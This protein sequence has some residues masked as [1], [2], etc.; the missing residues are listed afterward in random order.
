M[1]DRQLRHDDSIIN[2]A[3][4]VVVCEIVRSIVI[5]VDGNWIMHGLN[6]ESR[7]CALVRKLEVY[8]RIWVADI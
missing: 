1:G 5:I 4:Y 7:S 2:M 3:N 8:E 6:N